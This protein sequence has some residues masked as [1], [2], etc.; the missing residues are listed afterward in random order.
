MLRRIKG[1]LTSVLLVEKIRT[2]VDPADVA[3]V[4]RRVFKQQKVFYN[5][6]YNYTS[7]CWID[8]F[9]LFHLT[10]FTVLLTNRRA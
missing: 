1:F 6:C 10:L 8:V 9:V 4:A 5:I 3:L 7:S 2:T